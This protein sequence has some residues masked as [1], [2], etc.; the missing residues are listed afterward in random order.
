MTITYLGHSAFKLKGKRGT[1]ITDP[2]SQYVGF[3]LPSSSADMVVISHDH[4]DHSAASAIGGT[5]RRAEP[6]IINQPGEYEIGGISVFGVPSFHDDSKGSERGKN[7]IFTIYLD[8]M[9]VCH[10]GDLGHELTT[11]QIEQIG[12]VDIL[13]C[14]VGGVYSLDPEKA[15][16][17]IRSLEPSIVIPMHYKTDQHD[18][19]VFGEMEPL[20]SFLKAMSVEVKPEAKLEIEKTNL[21]EE[22]EVAVLVS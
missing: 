20:E 19:S 2:Y 17:V 9:R 14:P 22:T 8:E 16:K 6:F 12:P 1:V 11:E 5:A 10:L 4:P 7:T 15:V 21:P 18:E 13:M 3:S